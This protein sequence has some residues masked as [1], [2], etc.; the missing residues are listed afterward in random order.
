MPF[1]KIV[2]L[3]LIVQLNASLVYAQED[4]I[5]TGHNR[6]LVVLPAVFRSPETKWSGGVVLSFPFKINRQYNART[7][8]FQALAL[9]TQ[10]HQ[11]LG[12][13]ES[14]LYFNNED[15]IFRFHGTYSLFPDK[16]WGL[17]NHTKIN[18]VEEFTYEQFFIFPQLLKR[19]YKK[20]YAGISLEYQ[21]VLNLSYK[22]N[23]L[24]INQDIAGRSGGVVAGV[25][26]MLTWDNRDNA[27]SSTRGQLIEFSATVFSDGTE[28]EF[29]YT[30]YIFDG[31][32]YLSINSN[33]IIAFQIYANINRGVVPILSLAA[34]GGSSIMR[35]FYSGRFR[36]NNLIA[37][38]TEYRLHVVKKW[39]LVGFAGLGQVKSEI[40][41]FAINEFKYAFGGGIRFGLKPDERLN[42]RIDYGVTKNSSGIYFTIGEAF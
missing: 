1:S 36:D 32:K 4:T 31:R 5:R 40:R 7:S 8:N 3:L 9:Y 37:A 38:Q 14:T 2:I 17:G 30:N 34:M 11:K 28:S 15:Y 13:I 29:V 10:R 6:A 42:L 39:G 35:G 25:S 21:Q 22:P 12:G 27:F 23:G 18:D 20:F 41:R 24:I 19:I 16:F 26:G 33:Q